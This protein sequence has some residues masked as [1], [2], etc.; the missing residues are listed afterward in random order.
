MVSIA[1]W[2]VENLFTPD[3]DAGPDTAAEYAAKADALAAVISAMAPDVLALQ[4]IGDP[5][6][7]E[8]VLGRV[9][10]RWYVETADPDGRGIRMAIA[11]RTPLSEVYQVGPFLD[12]L[13]PVQVDDTGLG[14]RRWAGQRCMPLSRGC[15]Y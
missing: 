15:M 7:L 12:G 11:A 2:N 3:A 10:G 14:R 8:D 13:R 6:A 4:E 5:G 1:T 9:G